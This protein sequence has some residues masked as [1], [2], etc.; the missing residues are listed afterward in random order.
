MKME[1]HVDS[2]EVGG[3]SGGTVNIATKGG[4]NLL[5]GSAWEYNQTPGYQA[6]GYF[7]PH[8][9]KRTSFKQNQFGGTLSG[10]VVLPKL[11][12]GHNKTFFFGQYEDYR[13][14][15]T[16]SW[17]G[18]VATD[19]ELAGDFSQGS[20]ANF[21]IYDPASTT[22]DAN[23]YCTRTQFS[24]NGVN[25]VIPPGRLSAGN[26]AYVKAIIPRPTPV[27]LPGFNSYQTFGSHTDYYTYDWRIDEN[28]GSKDSAFFRWTA[29]KGNKSTPNRLNYSNV[30]STNAYTYAGNYVHVFSPNK[31]LH[32]EAGRTYNQISLDY[33]YLGVSKS[34]INQS[35]GF[36]A[37]LTSGYVTMGD[38]IPG[39]SIGNGYTSDFGS[40]KNPVT[41]ANSWSVRSDFTYVVGKHT[42]KFGGSYDSIGEAQ[43][44]EWGQVGFS[45]NETSSLHDGSNGYAKVT[46]HPIASLDVNAVSGF[47]KR[48]VDEGLTP[49]GIMGYFA[50]DQIQFNPRLTV[51]VGIR[52]DLALIP[53]YG[54]AGK[55]NQ[56]TGNF[57]FSNGTYIVLKTPGSCATLGTAPCIPTADGSLPAHVVS[58]PDGKILQNQYNNWQPRIGASFRLTPTTVIHG[59]VGLTFDNYAGLVQNLRGVSGNWPGVGQV[60]RS[61][62]NNPATG[63]PFPGYSTQNLPAMTAL[64]AATPFNQVNWF[65]A[66]NSKDAYSLQYNFGVQRQLDAATVVS[67]AYAGSTNKRLNIGANYNIAATP[68]PGDPVNRRP[69]PYISPTFYSWSGGSGNY[70]AMQVQLSRRFSKGLASTVAYT[71]GKSID[72]GCSGFFGSEG[73]SV[74]QVYNINKAERSVSAFDVTHNIV[75]SWNYALPM[76]RGKL[77]NVNNAIANFLIGNWQWSGFA[78][79]HS[80]TPYNVNLTADIAN[81]G[82][83]G[84]ERPNLVGNPVPSNRTYKNWLNYS[85]FAVPA[86]YTYGTV[87]RNPFRTQFYKTFDM[88]MYKEFPFADR[89]RVKVTADAFNIFNQ[90]AFGSPISNLSKGDPA[91]GGTFGVVNGTSTGA[92]GVQMSAKFTF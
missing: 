24:Y 41:S 30:S 75:A 66:P 50:Q 15:G 85:A 40:F 48:N 39:F 36:P 27:A 57:D 26:I 68:G 58:S 55:P 20:D 32:V 49:G 72:E 13:R 17:S 82:I 80:G 53:K 79:F 33:N 87:G 61:N 28:I 63:N 91:S 70:N 76:G 84:Y 38:A 34:T 31:I 42:F 44:I 92:R 65:I 89:Y 8:G 46:G 86:Q 16:S 90:H 88:S 67:L 60:A 29:L 64:P 4:T 47:T 7:T 59:G 78:K 3:S 69:Y 81:L 62:V 11:Y 18:L 9:T 25:N 74:Q 54:N 23:G 77:L 19:A 22:C 10:P 37:G 73:C 5:H 52:Y 14:S 6:L 2:A 83:N 1:A 71:W 43:S 56:Y 45:Q 35:V 12:N 21:P 51:N